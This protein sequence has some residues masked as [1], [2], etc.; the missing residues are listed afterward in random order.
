MTYPRWWRAGA[1]LAVLAVA[2]PA[3]AAPAPGDRSALTQV[4]ATAPLVLHL[5]GVEGTKDRLLVLAKNALPELEPML[6]EKLDGFFKDGIDGRKLAGLPKDGDVFLVFTEMPKQ[7]DNPPKIAVVLAVDKYAEFR[8]SLLKEDERKNLKTT[9]GV[10]R[11]TVDNGEAIYFVDKKGYAVVTPNEEVAAA[12]AK[13]PA[14]LDGAMSK[15]QA[16]KFLA[17]DF[18]LYLSMSTVN[19]DYAEQ[20][21]QAKEQITQGLDQAADN[22][23]KAQ[24]SSFD[25][26]KKMIG[27]I[28]QAVEDSQG[29]LLTVDFRPN[30]LAIHAQTELRNGSTTST[31]LKGMKLSG[32]GDLAK[33]PPGKIFY[34]GM[35]TSSRLYEAL[36]GLLLGA[37][38]DPDAKE[39]KTIAQ[40]IEEL[41]KAGPGT[42]VDAATIPAAGL[43]V[44]HFQDPAKAVA[45]QLKLVK[46]L[47]AGG[48]YQSGMLKDK[49]VVKASAKKYGDFDLNSVELTWDLEKMAEQA[50]MGNDDAKKQ[51]L[52]GFKSLLGEKL[53]VWFGTDG[54]AVVQV[55][56]Q[57]WDAAEKLLDGY[58]KGGKPVGDVAAFRTVRKELPP[59]ASMMVLA[60]VVQ[61]GVALVDV[62][63]PLV[64]P[65]V[66]LPPGFPAKPGKDAA[67]YVGM[68][69]SL[70]PE[71]G[72]ADVVLSA[73]AIHE[74]FKAFVQPFLPGAGN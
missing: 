74:A 23:P 4:P 71:R 55:S 49:P 12:L 60:D 25:L 36:G 16:A 14:G 58:F 61:Y 15:A 72:S 69:A 37:V 48:T 31:A 53:H 56:A 5:R 8:D 6:R 67:S 43:Q 2:R 64:P 40:A 7:G 45:A 30:A 66:P 73:T 54:K 19:K 46:A 11:T 27:P 41:G 70:Q 44:A 3:A 42:R 57:D 35:E 24:K 28:F 65:I 22:V 39:A 32:F 33:M 47:D 18:G 26:I 68:A 34:T 59:E 9:D 63:K 21:K 62:F 20:I 51:L 29:V 1:L 13:K 17:G 10:E 50:S 52:E 38:E